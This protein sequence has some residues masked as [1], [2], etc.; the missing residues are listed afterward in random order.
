MINYITGAFIAVVIIAVLM[1]LGK[2]AVCLCFYLW[3]KHK[4]RVD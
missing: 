4:G 3:D 2:L 1:E